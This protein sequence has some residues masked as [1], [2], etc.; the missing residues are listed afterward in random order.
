MLLSLPCVIVFVFMGALQTV[1]PQ[2]NV[3]YFTAMC[4]S[5]RAY[6][7]ILSYGQE[8]ICLDVQQYL[9]SEM[10]LCRMPCLHA[11]ICAVQCLQ[12]FTC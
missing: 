5:S 10:P 3:M 9:C 1:H 7:F 8:F 2:T 11:L 12:E 6:L 4:R